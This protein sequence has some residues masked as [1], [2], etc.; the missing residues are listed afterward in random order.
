[1]NID[2]DNLQLNDNNADQLTSF[3]YDSETSER[4]GAIIGVLQDQFQK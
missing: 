1:M 2:S 3:S 4:A